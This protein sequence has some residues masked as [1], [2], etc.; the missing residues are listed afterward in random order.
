MFQNRKRF[1]DRVLVT[2][3]IVILSHNLWPK[4]QVTH[5]CT[6]LCVFIVSTTFFGQ[7]SILF[8]SVG[9]LSAIRAFKESRRLLR[10]KCFAFWNC[11]MQPHISDSRGRLNVSR[12]IKQTFFGS[13][14]SCYLVTLFFTAYL[15]V[16][17]CIFER[18]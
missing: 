5:V 2:V 6:L 1:E 14:G 11:A 13:C 8:I 9:L 3:Y 12:K 15:G 17:W 10:S 16:L 18:F 7:F 4:I